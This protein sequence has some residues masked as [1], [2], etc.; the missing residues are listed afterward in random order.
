MP[1]HHG[2]PGGIKKKALRCFEWVNLVLVLQSYK[3]CHHQAQHCEETHPLMWVGATLRRV[4]PGQDGLC[5]REWDDIIIQFA[6]SF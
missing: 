1:L 4:A 3:G 2:L 6:Q 5:N